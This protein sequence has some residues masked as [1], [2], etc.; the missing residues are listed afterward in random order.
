MPSRLSSAV[1]PSFSAYS[2]IVS[3]PS[4]RAEL[5]EG[6]VAGVGQGLLYRLIAV[7]A[8]A[9][10]LSP[11][12]YHA[13]LTEQTAL[14]KGPVCCLSPQQKVTSLKTE[15]GVKEELRHLFR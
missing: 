13:A 8:G 12:H 2:A 9:G 15:P 7:G 10:E 3:P 1:M 4:S 14:S 6:T 11:V 5:A